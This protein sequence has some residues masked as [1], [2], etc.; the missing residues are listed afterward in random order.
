MIM[1]MTMMMMMMTMIMKMM[2]MTTYDD[3]LLIQLYPTQNLGRTFSKNTKT[4][5]KNS[6]VQFNWIHLDLFIA[7]V[8]SVSDRIIAQKNRPRSNLRT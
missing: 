4:V 3:V 7:C 5:Q 1:M 8:A 2:M 6:S